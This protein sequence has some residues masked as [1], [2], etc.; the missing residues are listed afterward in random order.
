[1]RSLF[2]EF[3]CTCI[4]QGPSGTLRRAIQTKFYDRDDSHADYGH[5]LEHLIWKCSVDSIGSI[6]V[7]DEAMR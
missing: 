6:T 7:V 1:M 5:K 2:S 3:S 4:F